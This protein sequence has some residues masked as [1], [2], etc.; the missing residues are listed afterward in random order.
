MLTSQS[1]FNQNQMIL[2][3][4]QVE[5]GGSKTVDNSSI[6]IKTIGTPLG[7]VILFALIL[8]GLWKLYEK[9]VDN[10][11]K[12]NSEQNL[13]PSNEI[14]FLT[15]DILID[16]E[17]TGKSKDNKFCDV[18]AT[19]YVYIESKQNFWGKSDLDKVKSSLSRGGNVTYEN[20]VNAVKPI[21]IY[22]FQKVLEGY[23]FDNIQMYNDIWKNELQQPIKKLG[24]TVDRVE[25]LSIEN[26]SNIRY[27]INIELLGSLAA[28]TKDFLRA[29]VRGVV[30]VSVKERLM[31]H[32]EI[33]EIV[34]QRAEQAI[35]KSVAEETL[36]SITGS[37]KTLLKNKIEEAFKVLAP[38]LEIHNIFITELIG[39]TL[40]GDEVYVDDLSTVEYPIDLDF[41]GS[42]AL[43]TQDFLRADVRGIVFVT[44]TDH[45]MSLDEI[46]ELVFHRAS[47]AFRKVIYKYDLTKITESSTE[48]SNNDLENKLKE[49]LSDVL[50]KEFTVTKVVIIEVKGNDFY[51]T[52]HFIEIALMNELAVRTKDHLR[53]NIKARAFVSLLDKTKSERNLTNFILDDGT[54]SEDRLI[55]HVHIRAESVFHETFRTMNFLHIVS[56]LS[57]ENVPEHNSS[58]SQENVP[59]EDSS[60]SQENVPE[61]NSSLSQKNVPEDNSS[62]SQENVPK[63]DSSLSQENSIVKKV[64]DKLMEKLE[65]IGLHL[66][67][68]AITEV[69]ESDFYIA[70]NDNNIL[71]IN[72]STARQKYLKTAIDQDEDIDLH[73]KLKQ[74]SSRKGIDKDEHDV[75]IQT[76]TQEL[77]RLK[78]EKECANVQN[79]IT[80][81]IKDGE[82]KNEAF[83][84]RTIGEA[85]A[86]QSKET[87]INNAIAHLIEESS[88]DLVEILSQ[89]AEI[90][91]AIGLQPGV[92]KDTHIYTLS[93]NNETRNIS[94]FARSLSAYPIIIQL[95]K[96]L[97]EPEK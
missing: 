25:F 47:Q 75:A 93:T 6:S 95:L 15:E 2:A 68:L 72:W 53:A 79:E 92:L 8:A 38:E 22:T 7:L 78:Q 82:A 44:T 9:S 35:R 40:S 1:K 58:L 63:E 17:F 18:N 29:G 46:K 87:T 13:F 66:D 91:K 31:S 12:D 81:I 39:L 45:Q 86:A 4:T 26:L 10:C 64:K 30:I 70:A 41:V 24:L 74:I 36:A 3:A 84:I 73:H 11:G 77:A 60:L 14:E 76:A 65:M 55:D 21:A 16:V 83:R 34:K 28:R 51:N 27:S 67:D 50:P 54:L 20:I 69:N 88:P 80:T 37:G 90:I 57:Q 5:T 61:D 97:M 52:I 71:D 49:S 48:P 33:N 62:L 56:S 19:V 32:E 42:S 23:N 85:Q 59:E 43:R 94:E 89:L 96:I